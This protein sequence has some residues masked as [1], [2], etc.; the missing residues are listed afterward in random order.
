MMMT[1]SSSN[2]SQATDRLK[3]AIADLNLADLQKAIDDGA[4]VNAT[5]AKK[6]FA[7][8]REEKESIETQRPVAALLIE[9]GPDDTKA[10][11]NAMLRA[12]VSDPRFQLTA[13]FPMGARLFGRIRAPLALKTRDGTLR[14]YASQLGNDEAGVILD[15]ASFRAAKARAVDPLVAPVQLHTLDLEKY[16]TPKV[17][18]ESKAKTADAALQLATYILEHDAQH[19][20]EI[21]DAALAQFKDAGRPLPDIYQKKMRGEWKWETVAASSEVSTDLI[22]TAK[23]GNDRMILFEL[24]TL[25]I[26]NVVRSFATKQ[27]WDVVSWQVAPIGGLQVV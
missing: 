20:K 27:G 17:V 15:A 2:T 11:R 18:V 7:T 9:P 12:L 3:A 10:K 13:M 4:D 25:R 8:F 23:V 1:S 19:P 21:I 6:L 16:Q 24:D 26:S 14:M 5:F 22:R